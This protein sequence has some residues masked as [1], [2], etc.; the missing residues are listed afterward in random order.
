MAVTLHDVATASGMSL[1]AVSQIM[2]GK[3]SYRAE[4]RER[5]LAAVRR[6]GYQPNMYAQAMTRR[7]FAAYAIILSN[8]PSSSL[9]PYGLLAGLDA[10]MSPRGLHLV[11]A[12]L[13]DRELT[14]ADTVPKILSHVLADGL[15]INYN[16]GY[17]R[18]AV[19]LLAAKGV[20]SVWL[21]V[22]HEQNAVHPD[23]RGAG[24]SMAEAFLAQGHRSLAWFDVRVG[25]DDTSK[26]YST[27]ARRDGFLAGCVGAR[28]LGL[29][30]ETSESHHPGY[31]DAIL[32]ASDRPTA[33]G[34]YGESDAQHVIVAALRRGLRVPQD[35]SVAVIGDRPMAFAG[36]AVDTL[37][38]DTPR[39][40][41]SAV[42]M[43]GRLVQGDGPLASV[44]IPLVYKPG[45]SIARH[46]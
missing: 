43:L 15:L 4:T 24:R 9:L 40:T 46:V 36:L 31:L 21:N 41:D 7:A 12:F 32:S 25:P 39:L 16:A 19:R 11:M 18:E 42:G 45:S 8:T 13:P 3:G 28:V 35:L 27:A 30:A 17:P 10:A 29:P 38:L 44:A 5:V 33:I 22:D 26:H 34:C 2:N 23:D 20:P 37:A 1:P 14:D 6:L